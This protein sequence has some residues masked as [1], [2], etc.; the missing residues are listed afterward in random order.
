[1]AP[2][3]SSRERVQLP[4]ARVRPARDAMSLM[5]GRPSM[6][7][8][9]TC[10]TRPTA[11]R[12]AGTRDRAGR[13]RTCLSARLRTLRRPAAPR[14]ADAASHDHLAGAPLGAAVNGRADIAVLERCIAE[15]FQHRRRTCGA[16]ARYSAPSRTA[17]R[18]PPRCR[19]RRSRARARGGSRRVLLP[20]EQ[21]HLLERQCHATSGRAWR[22]T[23][24]EEAHQR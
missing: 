9:P 19:R 7:T 3:A 17:L 5:R 4:L 1:M 21:P 6:H 22:G 13:A 8:Q 11:R 12:R 23:R 2:S 20:G 15:Q 10:P 16:I 14:E 18:A 24:Q